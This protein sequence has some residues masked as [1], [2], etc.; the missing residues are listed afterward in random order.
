MLV[1]YTS[2]MLANITRMGLTLALHRQSFFFKFKN[3]PTTIPL[4]ARS[5]IY[6]RMGKRKTNNFIQ[7]RILSLSRKLFNAQLIDAQSSCVTSSRLNFV[8]FILFLQNGPCQIYLTNPEH[9]EFP[10]LIHLKLHSRL[11][12]TSKTI[13]FCRLQ[14]EMSILNSSF[15]LS[16]PL[17]YTP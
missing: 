4:A 9:V 8:Y 5:T 6:S 14:S 16:L 12:P 1:G 15:E 7:H 10:L 2:I 13:D 3:N 17:T 11:S